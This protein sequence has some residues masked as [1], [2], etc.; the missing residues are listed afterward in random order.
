MSYT[1]TQ[2]QQ[3]EDDL[4]FARFNETDAWTLGSLLVETARAH[5]LPVAI[6]I[7][8]SDRVLFHCACPGTSPDNGY[9][10][11]RKKNTVRRFGH[12]SLYVGQKLRDA[13]TTIEQKYMVS[14]FEFAAHGGCFP[15]RVA[16][17]GIVAT[18]TVSGLAQTDDH[19]MA[20]AGIRQYLASLDSTSRQQNKE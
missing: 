4:L 14:E 1:L 8:S 18:V 9:W 17:V 6:D 16:D 10:I 2:L 5:N 20:V 3:Q 7:S 12:S 15:V 13:G 19:D 11:T